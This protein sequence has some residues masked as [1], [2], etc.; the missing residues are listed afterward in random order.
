MAETFTTNYALSKFDQGDNPPVHTAAKLN[1]NLD[2]IDQEIKNRDTFD[3]FAA[4]RIV[5]SAGAG[6]HTTIAAALASMPAA[7]GTIFLKGGAYN[8][9]AGLSV[10]ANVRIVGA[11]RNSTTINIVGAITL[12]TTAG[13]YFCLSEVTVVGDDVTAQVVFNTDHDVDIACCDFED[14]Y[15]L[16]SPVS[17]AAEVSMSDCYVTMAGGAGTGVYI[18]KGVTGGTLNWDYVELSIPIVDCKLIEGPTPGSAGCD[19][20]V[21][22]SYTGGPPPVAENFYYPRSIDWLGLSLDGAIVTV[23]GDLNK[24][25]GCHFLLSQLTFRGAKN[26]V[27]NSSFD[28]APAFQGQLRVEVLA[29]APA[30]TTIS[31]CTFKNASEA[32]GN[33]NSDGVVISG[34]TFES[35]GVG[36]AGGTSPSASR[37]IVTGC[38]FLGISTIYEAGPEVIGTYTGN[39]TLSGGAS[40]VSPRSVVDGENFRN[41]LMFGG[42]PDGV[43]NNSAAF[44]SAVSNLPPAG[45]TIFFPPGTY[46][47]LFTG[48]LPD[49]PVTVRGCGDSSVIDITSGS[50]AAFTVPDGLTEVRRY[51][52]VDLKIAGGGGGVATPVGGALVGATLANTFASAP[53]I[54]GGNGTFAAG[55]TAGFTKE[56]GEPNHGVPP[57]AGGASGWLEWT[58]P[59]NGTCTIDL[60]GSSFDTLLSI[61]TGVSVGAL[62]LIAGDDDSGAGTTSLVAFAAVMG[63]SYKIAVDGFGGASGTVTFTMT[64][65]A[66]GAGQIN[67]IISVEDSN[68]RGQ[69]SLERV[70]S[71]EVERPIKVINAPSVASAVLIDV[72]DC[73]F[74]QA[75]NGNSILCYN[76]PAEPIV[77]L[78]MRRVDFFRDFHD[79]LVGG[80]LAL[81]VGLSVFT[82]I[83]IVAEDCRLAVNVGCS[84]GA[85]HLRGCDLYNWTAAANPEIYV[86]DDNNASI[87][88]VVDGCHLYFVSFVLDGNGT[89]FTD[90][91]M[92]TCVF[93][94]NAFSSFTDCDFVGTVLA[95]A[96]IIGNGELT[97]IGC[98]F[99]NDSNGTSY[100]IMN[101]GVVKGCWIEDAPVASILLDSPI[102]SFITGNR[103]AFESG[104]FPYTTPPVIETGGY[105]NARYTDNMWNVQPVL[106]AG[107]SSGLGPGAATVLN[108]SS[109]N[110]SKLYQRIDFATTSSFIKFLGERNV[111]GLIAIGHLKN[112]GGVNDLEARETFTDA[113]G[114]TVS[115]TTVVTPGSEIQLLALANNVS[116]ARPPYVF[117]Q[118]EVRHPIATTTFSHRVLVRG[119]S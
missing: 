44:I 82:N 4:T 59:A 24:A 29:A 15:G 19:W 18:W 92:D 47:L 11:G 30:Q 104:S 42:N 20:K 38:N 6:T 66:G 100:V 23:L 26:Q 46:K 118:L 22:H 41:I 70:N 9:S 51:H 21:V 111:S 53:S 87:Y 109:V 5:D 48:V 62:T 73:Y 79:P 90:C 69:V 112:T 72:V 56:G 94:D 85:L 61:Y 99:Y 91:Y 55:S 28:G 39:N 54:T 83:N 36:S 10:P 50:F 52:I 77:N 71:Y 3:R 43:T 31:G 117:Y 96:V 32:I 119:V 68:A 27:S 110:G 98:R 49:K 108:M 37:T 13:G 97:V 76:S 80:T 105:V 93:T 101:P 89:K 8:I 33:L 45:G 25:T 103:I 115:Q 116:T 75:E 2:T 106:L 65:I 114:V 63:T 58:A 34:C 7:G 60:S 81:G 1:A 35:G 57:N 12:F 40:L 107:N 74:Q 78:S 102:E 17:S 113:Y 16:I 88:S 86:E 67:N 14:I 84:V 95:A 64:L